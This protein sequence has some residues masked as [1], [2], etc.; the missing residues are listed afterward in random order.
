MKNIIFILVAIVG[1]VI[2]I[3]AQ[4]LIQVTD[5]E[6]NV[7]NTINIG[8][9]TWMK[10]N[11]RT[12]KLNDGISIPLVTS[13]LEWDALSSS[14]YSWYNNDET[15]YKATYGALYNWYVVNTG[16]LCP[17]DWHIPTD[18]EWTVL[19]DFLGSSAGG[20][21]K[22]TGTTRWNSPNTGSTN[23]TGFAGLPGG[24]R[25]YSGVFGGLGTH[26]YMWSSIGLTAGAY[27]SGEAW[28]RELN[29]FSV[30]VVRNYYSR[31]QG[32]SVRCVKDA[33]PTVFDTS[34]TVSSFGNTTAISMDN[35]TLQMTASILPVNATVQEVNWIVLEG[36]GRA[37]INNSGLLTAKV[38]GTVTVKATT[39]DGT[40]LT[41]SMII[42]LSNQISSLADFSV[43]KE[44]DFPTNGDIGGA[45]ST[46][47]D[48]GGTASVVNGVCKMI[49]GGVGENWHLQVKQ[50]GWIAYND[51]SYV[52]KF[53]AW[54]DAAR[55]FTIDFEDAIYNNYNRFGVSTDAE[56]VGGRSEWLVPLSTTPTT[57]TFH[58]TFDQIQANTNFLLNIMTSAASAAVYIDDISLVKVSD[59]NNNQLGLPVID[60]YEYKTVTIGTQTWMAENL[61]TTKFRNGD[62]IGT[63]TPATLNISSESAPKY[64]WA[65][66][67]NESNVTTYGRLYTWY[68][69]TDIRNVCPTGWHIPTDSEW[70]I[71]TDYLTNNGYG[72]QGSGS[73]I[74]KSMAAKS[75]WRTDATAGNVG[76]DQASNNS[77]GFSALPGGSRWP[78]GTFVYSGDDGYWWC[79][80]VSPMS[81]V[82]YMNF[83]SSVVSRSYSSGVIGGVG[84]SVRCLKDTQRAITIAND[85][86]NE[87]Q[88]LEVPIHL[89]NLT[90]ADNIISFQFDVTYDNTILEY[91]GNSVVGTLSEGGT[92]IVN[93]NIAG[94]L[95]IGNISETAIIGEGV[96]LKLQFNN[97]KTDTTGLS[98]SNAYLNNTSVQ[99]LTNGTIIVKDVTPPTAT[100]TYNEVN[101]RCADSLKI[102]A[103]FSEPMLTSNSV[104]VSL[105]GAAPL[106]DIDMTRQS[107][108]IYTFSY[109]VPKADGV[110][111]VTLGN[112]TDLWGNVVTSTPTTG[113][114]FTI[115]KI[116][117]GDVDDDGKILAYDAALTLQR[118]VDLDPLPS[119]DPIPW[120]NWRDT[121]ANV[122]G[123]SGI[124][125]FDAG[126]ILEYS[127]GL[128]TTFP[129][130]GKKSFTSNS[131]ADVTVEIVNHD[132]VFYSNGDLMGLN[133]STTNTNQI[134]GTPSVLAPNFL[135]AFN[136][137]GTSY[138]VGICTAN[139][140]V[141]G[142]AL[143]KIPYTKSGSV[144]FTLNVNTELKTVTI[145]LVTGLVE[146]SDD[147]I[148]IYP[149]PVKD[150]LKISGIESPTVARIHNT[151]GKL[152]LTK[153]LINPTSEMNVSD[154]PAG[155]YIIKL[156]TDKEIAVKR[157]AIK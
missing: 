123:I 3:N 84:S 64:Q 42:T 54:S 88:L 66:D 68:A 155:V 105:S 87:G 86:V 69:I 15:S 111:N 1:L 100:I 130:D 28:S 102:T 26:G 115:V 143:L 89:S 91:I 76:N 127:I 124:T 37:T 114:S 131:I 149:N 40:L 16:K 33:T 53:T 95:S 17:T 154:L 62:L 122:D 117:Y 24:Y 61:K 63:T 108:T 71:L 73:D 2:S 31:R 44:G 74:G 81:G 8:T 153:Q 79:Y 142:V 51:T 6:G 57:F 94:K 20:M 78:S 13:E 85:S 7:Y 83:Y 60:G 147:N 118:S 67:G 138:K 48:N 96:I 146:F 141:D 104:K 27:P 43:I 70:T 99:N 119:I 113:N 133:I 107:P 52:F 148:S 5:V 39:K 49:P 35:G 50:D 65:Y 56:S 55:V 11:L 72:Y 23:A 144:T 59:I 145:D 116:N 22:E 10:E 46:W 151:N 12:T 93:A 132:I 19:T 14:G 112:G 30:N 110:V 41:G 156:Q 58:V 152:L 25:T 106:T 29:N 135:S 75:G 121:T 129:A 103:T 32:I 92:V 21:L 128:I 77:S 97:L 34:I 137:S 140:P 126:M 45:W 9:Q 90:A 38:N 47:T 125:A 139:S 120:E 134:L 136:I 157:I 80:S 98:L 18:A 82:R 109:Y 4:S 101:I 150:I 36:T